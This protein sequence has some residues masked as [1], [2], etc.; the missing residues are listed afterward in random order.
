MMT[1][2]MVANGAAFSFKLDLPS[3]PCQHKGAFVVVVVVVNHAEQ[4]T[5]T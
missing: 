1:F 2:S 5:E 3:T 4:C